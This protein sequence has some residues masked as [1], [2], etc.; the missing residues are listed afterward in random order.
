MLAAII[1]ALFGL[2]IGSFLNVCIFR[3]PRDLSVVRPRSY[4]PECEHPIAWYDN[5]PLLS[6]LLLRG[7]CRNCHKPIRARY[8]IVE[9][10]A[11]A[12]FFWIVFE[13][14]LSFQ[15]AKLCTLAALLIGLAFA[16][17]EELILPD[18]FTLGGIVLG[19]LFAGAIPSTGLMTFLLP[20]RWGIRWLS[21]CDAASGAA[22][23]S[24]M[25]WT[26][27]ALYFRFRH[28]E[29]M[30]LGDV[31]MIGMVAAFLGFSGALLAMMIGAL[32]GSVGGLAYIVAK[33]KSVATYE[34]PFGTFVSAAAMAVAL[35]Q[36]YLM[37]LS[38]R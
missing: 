34:L 30:G 36:D 3:L 24:G 9:F 25:L 20:A 37:R 18:E 7:R 27:R 15:A 12:L 38:M 2:L 14:G 13:Y 29:G 22:I 8:P 16:D 32:L 23:A 6:Y 11:G 4:C 10:L 17:L 21:V 19:V 28:R 35:S 26:L 1:A 31:K 33:K 5:I